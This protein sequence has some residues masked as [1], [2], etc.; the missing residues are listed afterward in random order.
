MIDMKRFA[1]TLAFITLIIP[2]ISSGETLSVEVNANATD[3]EGK[4]DYQLKIAENDAS[5]G[6][7]TIY[8]ADDYFFSNLNGALKDEVFIPG[9]TLGLG[10]KGLVGKAEIKDNEFDLLAIGFLAVGDYDFRKE[11]PGLP[12]VASLSISF[13]P[14]P[15]SFLESKRYLE[16]T[17][18]VSCYLIEKGAVVAG[19][20]I[21]QA[22]FDNPSSE[23]KMSDSGFYFGLKLDF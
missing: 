1:V 9:L 5:I 22:R 10:L 16:F 15:L 8:S 13:A 2:K 14:E 19:Y 6:F 11:F 7:G 4:I 21:I 20:R 17:G 12:L 23:D 18:A 3:L